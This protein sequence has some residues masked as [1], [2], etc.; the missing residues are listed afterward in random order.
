M[1]AS[2][3]YATWLRYGVSDDILRRELLVSK[4]HGG[5]YET[6]TTPE[7]MA[8]SEA[9]ECENKAFAVPPELAPLVQAQQRRR[10]HRGISHGHELVG[11]YQ[12]H[13]VWVSRSATLRMMVPARS[14][15]AEW[16]GGHRSLS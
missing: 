14:V 6:N 16:R 4:L 2:E 1:K 5:D 7:L 15:G 3:I 10:H 11:M 8:I 9:S 12:V 13:N